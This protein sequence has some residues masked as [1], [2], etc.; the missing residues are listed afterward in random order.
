M[1]IE[2]AAIHIAS[3]SACKNLLSGLVF[4]YYL[5]LGT[6]CLVGASGKPELKERPF[7]LREGHWL[8]PGREDGT[9]HRVPV[10]SK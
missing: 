10:R 4:V 5:E 3:A 7:L 9:D 6:T 8:M 1:R 2:A